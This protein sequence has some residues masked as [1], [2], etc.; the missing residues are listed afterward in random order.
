MFIIFTRESN[1][2]TEQMLLRGKTIRDKEVFKDCLEIMQ[3]NMTGV[4]FIMNGLKVTQDASVNGVKWGRGIN[5]TDGMT[6]WK[7]SGRNVMR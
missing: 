3:E 4:K 5:Y 1:R 7:I 6:R 2:K